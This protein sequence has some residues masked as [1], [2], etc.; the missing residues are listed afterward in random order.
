MPIPARPT[1]PLIVVQTNFALRLFQGAFNGPPAPGH[2]H[3]GD[4]CRRVWR[5]DDVRREL[6]GS[7]QTPADQE[8]AAPV[9]LPRRAQGEPPPVIPAWACGP[10]ASAEPVPACRP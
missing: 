4:Q 3:H 7:A 2:L 6:R 8:P 9:G 5:K 1:P 10:V